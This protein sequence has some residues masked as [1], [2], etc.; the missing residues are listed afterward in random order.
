MDIKGRVGVRWG[1]P[2]MSAKDSINV[3]R[4]RKDQPIVILVD[5][6]AI[7]ILDETKVRERGFGFTR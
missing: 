7:E 2:A 1:G 5:I 6:N 4:T 3:A